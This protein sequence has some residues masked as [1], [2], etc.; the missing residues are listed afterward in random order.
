MRVM[1]AFRAVVMIVALAGGALIARPYAHGLSFV[2]RAAEMQGAARRVADLDA[3]AVSDR[4]I[5]IP[6]APGPM[7]A[8]VYQPAGGSHRA[9]LLTSGL[10]VSGID[11]PRLVRLAR[12]LAGNGLTI[13]TPDIAE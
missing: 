5:T 2:I 11:E 9:A 1:R 8:R 3:T 7:R 6:T 12:Q 13:V 10:H 4:E